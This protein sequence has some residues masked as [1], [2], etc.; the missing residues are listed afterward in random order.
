VALDVIRYVR[1]RA[2][3]RQDLTGVAL[4]EALSMCLL[5]QLE[6]LDQDSAV[7][8]RDVMMQ[9]LAGWTSLE[10]RT[11]LHARMVELFP[12]VKWPSA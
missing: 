1:R 8:A 2:S 4:A 11:D 9:A 3:G 5:P 10:A 7:Q 12:H 6:G